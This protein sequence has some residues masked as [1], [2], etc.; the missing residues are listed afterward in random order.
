MPRLFLKANTQEREALLQNII[1]T[2]ASNS[3]GMDIDQL[4]TLLTSR[5][6]TLRE[7]ND[8]IYFLKTTGKNGR[9][10]EER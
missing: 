2:Y 4:K 10:L 3:K 1:W 7:V 5:G 6:Y 8:A 9:V